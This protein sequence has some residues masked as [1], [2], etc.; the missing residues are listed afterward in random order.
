M[1]GKEVCQ[2]TRER[3]D[4][5]SACGWQGT[6]RA[7]QQGAPSPPAGLVQNA[8]LHR[9]QDHQL[10]H[11][12]AIQSQCDFNHIPIRRGGQREGVGKSE[13]R[14]EDCARALASRGARFNFFSP[15]PHHNDSPS[16]SLHSFPLQLAHSTPRIR[17]SSPGHCTAPSHAH[18]LSAPHPPTSSTR[19][20]PT[21]QQ[22]RDGRQ[23]GPQSGTR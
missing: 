19:H 6:R 3:P 4:T 1:D 5:S 23:V 22:T 20:R 11:C 14:G 16:L 10:S 15:K 21:A 7:F 8:L 17:L 2:R 18:S 9:L 13:R 12:H